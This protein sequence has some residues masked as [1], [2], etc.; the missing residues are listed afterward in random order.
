M[1]R[2]CEFI[3]ILILTLFVAVV[4]VE[5]TRKGPTGRVS[6]PYSGV[7]AILLVSTLDGKMHAVNRKNGVIL[8]TLKEDPVLK[9]P[10]EYVRG[11]TFLPDPKD[12]SMYVLGADGLKKLPFTIP[13][14]VAASPCKSADGI[15]Y[16]GRKSDIW[17][18]I[19]PITG[20]KQQTLTMDGSDTTCPSSDSAT[21]FI[22]RTEYTVTMFDSKTKE[23]RWNVTFMD[24]SSHVATDNSDYDLVHFS[25]SS[26]GLLV[27][28]NRTPGEILW[29]GQYGS[30]VVAMYSLSHDGLRKVAV[31][32]VAVETLH[33]LT[34][35][36]SD[37]VW[38]ARFLGTTDDT[39]LYP[40]LYIGQYEHGLFAMPS[41]VE[42]N[43]VPV[44]P[45]DHTLP[46]IEGPKS[47]DVALN[48]IVPISPTPS[49]K[50]D[51]MKSS[52]ITIADI[53]VARE[54]TKPLIL[55]YHEIPENEP[56]SLQIVH[57]GSVVSVIRPNIP[58]IAQIPHETVEPLDDTENQTIP[59]D[60]ASR[61]I[62]KS[63]SREVKGQPHEDRVYR[64]V[65]NEA[66]VIGI[67]I[68]LLAGLII[69]IFFAQRPVVV[70]SNAPRS[71]QT[72]TGGLPSDDKQEEEVPDGFIK[73]GKIMF[74]PKAVLGQGCEGT[75]VYKGY[76][77]NR[78]VAV[79][80]ILPECFNF[81]DREVDLLRESD[82]HRHV[83]RYFCM[84]EDKQFR[85]I[86]LELCAATLQD[87]VTHG[88]FNTDLQERDVL[89][90][91]MDGLAYLHSLDIVHRDIK[92][93]NVL[94]SMPNA[95]G[96][97]K[98]MISDF[99]LCKKLAAGRHSF[100][101]RS[102]AA[103]T[104][105]WIAPE[106]LT[107]EARTT[108]AVDIFSAGCVFYYVLSKGK[109]PFGDSLH[110]QANILM[111]EYNLEKLDKD[112]HLS[113]TLIQ[114]MITA[115][116]A[117][118]PTAKVI[119]KH[120]FFWSREKQLGFFQDVSDRIEKL[121]VNDPVVIELERNGR[122]VVKYDWRNNITLELQSD[123]RKFRTYRGNSVRDLLRA[124]R[125]KKHHYRELPE[126]VKLSLGAVPEEFVYYFTSRFPKLLLHTYNV[127]M[128][129]CKGE[130]LF[131]QYYVQDEINIK[132]GGDNTCV[133][134]AMIRNGQNDGI[135]VEELKP[136]HEMK[137]ARESQTDL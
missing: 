122:E 108:T 68:S 116:I 42:E 58:P 121:P 41:M 111:A 132:N 65:D 137:L 125:N 44:I 70:V 134:D 12:G 75:F 55:G 87:Y 38:R 20:E 29:D 91:A 84:E 63:S 130:R 11:P 129:C 31:S 71:M 26:D 3:C 23:K 48:S 56:T 100:S 98:A 39:H 2:C 120:P 90:Q 83:I 34:G 49:S 78:D 133:K 52:I 93:H 107:E 46:M 99:G 25:S 128:M 112:D 16:T 82:E 88:K 37:S 61:E 40:T 5:A 9:V 113:R 74:N 97:V 77:D 24:Y 50:Y 81:A 102:G 35:D 17:L 96:E 89:Y 13:E 21:L 7:D 45:R 117:D 67:F 135:G 19:D 123:L 126:E 118:R 119:L 30:P 8:W 22:G 95:H 85:Y 80:R 14:L 131:R 28:M 105:G 124:M 86:A 94:I 18:A 27:T 115:N 66:V 106:M 51:P 64:L 15:L 53:P 114:R 4:S 57:I 72:S 47:D 33:H 127:I 101:R 54:N 79:K 109:H 62:S 43:T 104:E 60:T 10:P 36:V 59:D 69:V 76:F 6:I 32:N 1:N 136:T 103:G 73:I 110:R 92:P